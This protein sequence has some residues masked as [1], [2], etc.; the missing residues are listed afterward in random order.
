[1]QGIS[2]SFSGIPVLRNVDF[3]LDPGEIV[4]L[5]GEN[6]A[7]KSTLMK[8]LTG[9][10][11]EYEGRLLF[12]GREVRF[13]SPADAYALGISI[14]FQEF[15]LCPNLSAMENLFLGHEHRG[16]GNLF[17]YAKTREEARAA[18]RDLGVEIDPDAL[19]RDLG[20]AQQQM[21][22]IAKALSHKP[23]ILV[24]DEPTAPLT[25]KEINILFRLMRD[26]KSRGIAIV[27]ISHKLKEVLE[28]SDRVVCLRDGEISGTIDTKSATEN[29]LISMMVGREIDRFYSQRKGRA[30]EEV[31]FEVRGLSGPP[32]IRDVS[33]RVRRGEI[34]G[35]A[36]LIGAGRTEVA[37]L[38]VGAER[39]ISGQLLLEGREV[40]ID[41]P[42][43]AVALGIGYVTEDRKKRGLVLPM[44]VRENS[45]LSIHP[46]VSNP[47]GLLR[48]AAEREVADRYIGDLRI[49]VSGRE[50]VV[51]SLSGG[52]QQ[53]VLLAKW[54]AIRPKFLILDEPTRGIDVGAKSEIHRIIADL[55]DGGMSILVIS[56]ELPEV[57]HLSD[58]I[59]VMHE[60]RLTADIPREKADEE[61]IMKAA[62]A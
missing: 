37:R 7:G 28:I 52:N 44:T 50:Q 11:T 59:L 1:M 21:I 43:D 4:C 23:K 46:L 30:G 9:V 3:G 47:L 53:K 60:G 19:V 41:H 12:E 62:V 34:V 55:A 49:K 35:L 6:G 48:G 56:S 25:G 27:F 33:F 15:N 10:H 14:V 40:R 16:P 13:R 58:R 36:G 24:M 17:S 2:K 18:F 39:K 38:I 45:T 22:E 32:R 57:L 29:G 54:L 8:I 5:L 51:R 26:L 61:T 42:A 20:V 31:V